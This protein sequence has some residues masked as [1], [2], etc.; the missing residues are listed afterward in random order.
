MPLSTAYTGKD[1]ISEGSSV[2]EIKISRCTQT[3]AEQ[4]RSRSV[5]S[6]RKQSENIESQSAGIRLSSDGENLVKQHLAKSDQKL[7]KR[8]YRK[9]QK[10]ALSQHLDSAAKTG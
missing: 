8:V 10:Q 6:A 4:Q 1:N 7:T 9:I 3:E 5:S 2:K